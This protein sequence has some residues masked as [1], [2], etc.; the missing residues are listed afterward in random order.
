MILSKSKA[1][2]KKYKKQKGISMVDIAIWAA[3]AIG[4]VTIFVK[5]LGPVL[6]QNRARDEITEMAKVFSNIQAKWANSPNFE[7]VDIEGLISNSVFPQSWV[8]GTNVINRWGGSVDASP[9]TINNDNDTLE[10]TSSQV[11]A[12]ECKNILPGLYEI[13]KGL[14]AGGTV[15]KDATDPATAIN[16][17]TVGEAC[18]ANGGNPIDIVYQIGK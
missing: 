14:S 9:T 13:S 12:E 15:V 17:T 10:I 6:S 8:S 1:F 2:N 3:V 7:N 18:N 5:S 11:P 4:V 16:M